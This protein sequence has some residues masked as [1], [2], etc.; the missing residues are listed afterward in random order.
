LTTSISLFE[1]TE[2]EQLRGGSAFSNGL[3]NKGTKDHSAVS[4]SHTE[5]HVP[6]S[7]FRGKINLYINT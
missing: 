3:W 7:C 1:S 5:A 4:S 2:R 6:R